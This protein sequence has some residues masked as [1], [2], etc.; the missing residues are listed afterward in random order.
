MPPVLNDSTPT[1]DVGDPAVPAAAA[2]GHT[3]SRG[4]GSGVAVLQRDELVQ[5]D[6]DD[7][8]MDRF[9][10]QQLGRNSTG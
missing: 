5:S 9:Y 1:V 3:R 7:S 2:A 6:S 8:E 10:S 4:S